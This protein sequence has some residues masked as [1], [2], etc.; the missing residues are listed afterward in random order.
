M[1]ALLTWFSSA[2]IDFV[3]LRFSFTAECLDLFSRNSLLFAQRGLVLVYFSQ[4]E[5]MRSFCSLPGPNAPLEPFSL[6]LRRFSSSPLQFDFP[7]PLQTEPILA[8]NSENLP[9]TSSFST[10]CRNPPFFFLGVFI[11][12][13]PFFRQSNIFASSL[14]IYSFSQ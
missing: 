3:F 4:E 14:H 2:A 1:A 6:C 10:R 5:C 12:R 11:L 9:K 8:L 13:F 7:P